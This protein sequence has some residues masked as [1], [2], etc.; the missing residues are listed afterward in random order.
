[1]AVISP[2]TANRTD[3]SNQW[4][5]QDFLRFVGGGGRS[6]VLGF[7]LAAPPVLTDVHIEY[8]RL[9]HVLFIAERTTAFRRSF[10]V[11]TVANFLV[12]FAV[13]HP[14]SFR[15]CFWR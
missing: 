9:K 2:A 14:W 5:S 1:V 8:S 7:P 3:N 6:V 11:L 4:R 13:Q 12:H 10:D 15:E